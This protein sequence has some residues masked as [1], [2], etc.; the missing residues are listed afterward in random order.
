MG[1]VYSSGSWKAK[2]GEEEQFVAAWSEFATWIGTM[3]GSGTARLT[4][5]VGEP[6]HYVS[7]ADWESDDAM[8][9]WKSNPAFPEKL[10]A[11]RAHV[12]EFTPSE[13]ELVTKV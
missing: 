12:A 3:P 4:Q 9:A 1:E 2:D 8:Q 11:V 13:W 6:G 5:D 7:F 10:G